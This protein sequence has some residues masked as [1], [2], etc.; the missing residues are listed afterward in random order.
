MSWIPDEQRRLLR[1]SAQA[2]C[3]EQLPVSQLRAFATDADARGYNRPPGAVSAKQ[4]YAAT[5]VPEAHGAGPGA[6][7]EPAWWPSRSATRW[8][9]RLS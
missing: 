1:D 8:Q 3:V 9:P 5:L 7:A 6:P 4:G 2:K